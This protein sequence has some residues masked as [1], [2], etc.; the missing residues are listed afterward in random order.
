MDKKILGDYTIL[1]KIGQGPLG[2]VVL[3]EHRFIKK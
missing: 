2:E 3:G 1:K